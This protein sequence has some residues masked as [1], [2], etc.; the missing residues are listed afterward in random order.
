MNFARPISTGIWKERYP[1]F[2]MMPHWSDRFS[3]LGLFRILLNSTTSNIRNCFWRVSWNSNTNKWIFWKSLISMTKRKIECSHQRFWV[4]LKSTSHVSTPRIISL[5][6]SFVKRRTSLCCSFKR[7]SKKSKVPRKR[8]WKMKKKMRTIPS[9]Y[10][11]TVPNAQVLDLPYSGQT[12]KY[13]ICPT[14][15]LHTW[16]NTIPLYQIWCPRSKSRKCSYPIK[17][18]N[19]SSNLNDLQLESRTNLSVNPKPLQYRKWFKRKSTT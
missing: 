1:C 14:K 18:N 13:L 5:K 19:G 9:G 7:V 12:I 17:L 10:Q 4:S 11:I 3:V 6:A 2:N 8:I 16:E 15:S